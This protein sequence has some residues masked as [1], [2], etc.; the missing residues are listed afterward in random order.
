MTPRMGEF[1]LIATLLRP[2]AAGAPGALGLGDDAAVL[3]PPAGQDLVVAKDAMVEGV[4]FLAADP[5]DT[6]ARKLLRTNLSD[7]AAMGAEPWAYLT[8]LAL[9]AGLDDAWLS[10]FAQGL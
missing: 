1:E 9:P 5:P 3:R 4:H 6:I 10:S 2:L 8:A 7:L